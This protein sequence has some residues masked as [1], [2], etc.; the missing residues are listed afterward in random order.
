MAAPKRTL[1][2]SP[3]DGGWGWMIVAGCFLVTI[4]TR[5]VTRCISIFFVEFQTYFAQDYAQTAWIHSIVDCVT[6]LCAPLGSVISNHLSCQVGIMLG[7][8]LA[9]TGLIL[10]S[11]ATSLKHL[12]LTLGVLT[13]LG[14]ALCYSPAIAMVGKYFNKRRA[15]AYGIATSGSGIGTFILAPVV[16][17]LI[18]QFS[19][20]GA[21]LI[22]GGFVLNLCVCGALMRPITLKEDHK[23]LPKQDPVSKTPKENLPPLSLCSPLLKECTQPCLC[24][25]LQQEYH[26]LLIADFVVFATS[27]L[28]MAYGCSPLFVYLVPYALSVGVSHQQAAFLMSILGVINIIGNVTFGWLTDRRCL[29]NSRYVCYLFAVGLDGLCYLFLP[30]LQ[31]FPLLV[32]FSCTFGYFDGAYVTLIPVVTAEVVGTTSLS[33]ALGVVYFLHAVPY[34]VSPP[35][36]GWLVDT[37][38]SYTAAFLLC[39]FSMI[40]SSILLSFARLLKKM[41]TSQVQ[42]LDEDA[43]PKLQLWPN[44]TVAYSVAGE[45]DH[46]DEDIM[47]SGVPG[48]HT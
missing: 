29:K 11:F 3:P 26:F 2:I 25:S 38:G 48:Y 27:I 28:F 10:S 17:L 34:L 43:G 31:S 1:Y 37:T 44:G 7:G 30:M 12:Y 21:L 18:E 14:F 45:L 22:L 47:T 20:R 16:Q 36:A 15:L 4:C 9:S 35:I 32:P 23:N 41:K 24:C 6:M 46:K 13:G 42:S 5:A 8:L 33:S 40:F 39:G 19:W